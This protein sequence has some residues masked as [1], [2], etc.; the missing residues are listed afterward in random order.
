MSD[1]FRQLDS[2]ARDMTRSLSTYNAFAAQLKVSTS[3]FTSVQDALN[4]QLAFDRGLLR[5]TSDVL[6]EARLAALTTSNLRDLTTAN[7]QLAE[8]ASASSIAN[9]RF[10]HVFA[11]HNALRASLESLAVHPSVTTLLS[12]MDTTSLLHTSIRSQCRLLE[13]ESRSFGQSI[14][15]SNTL[16]NDLVAT[17]GKLTRS[18]RDVV[19][20]LPSLQERCVPVIAKYSP[21][22]YSLE[23]GVLERVSADNNDVSD[24]GGLPSVDDELASFDKRLL[25]LIN[26][27]RESLQNENPDRAR[28][29][30]TSVRELFTHVLHALAPDADVR[31]WSSDASHYHNNRPTRRARLLYIC[32]KFSCDP[33]SQFVEDDV[34]AALTL[35]DSLNEGT[36]VIQS[37]LTYFQL[38][39]IVCRMEALALFLLKL[40][41]DG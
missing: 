22:E 29:V 35:I 10:S 40:S 31:K 8:L 28:H 19:E 39:A 14:G 24:S 9:S 6:S 41:R 16:S 27:A 2:I 11:E 26:G 20:C 23:L 21:L 25:G 34:R 12:S 13:L 18:Y 36:H 17:L 33:L 7:H 5:V 38:E 4:T 15:A 32:R 30:T 37:R 1:G 3:A